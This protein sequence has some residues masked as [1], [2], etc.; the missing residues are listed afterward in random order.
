[1][2]VRF[3]HG[4]NFLTRRNNPHDVNPMGQLKT[5]FLV[6]TRCFIS[7]SI[8]IWRNPPFKE[9]VVTIPECLYCGK[10]TTRTRT[11]L[12]DD[13]LISRCY[14]SLS[15]EIRDRWGRFMILG[16]AL[17]WFTV[18]IQSVINPPF[19]PFGICNFGI[20]LIGV[21]AFGAGMV[22]MVL[23][24]ANPRKWFFKET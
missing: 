24:R 19:L 21:G 23:S 22:G 9:K 15:C 17:L 2:P 18:G 14:C 20:F 10:Q 7:A 6:I 16:F 5:M 3:Y 12:G 11:I 13:V 1:M 8:L 4:W